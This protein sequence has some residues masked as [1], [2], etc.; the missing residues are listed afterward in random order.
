M[1]HTRVYFAVALGGVF[2]VPE[3]VNISPLDFYLPSLTKFSSGELILALPARDSFIWRQ[4]EFLAKQRL[5][6]R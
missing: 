6:T 1:G 4:A 5:S 3:N 2:T